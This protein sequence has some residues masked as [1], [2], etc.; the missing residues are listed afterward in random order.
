MK[1]T[2]KDGKGKACE[3]EIGGNPTRTDK[4][5]IEQFGST[6]PKFTDVKV[7]R[8]NGEDAPDAPV[9]VSPGE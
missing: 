1:I 4:E 8:D 7:V 3:F 9:P 5:I 6:H 2:A